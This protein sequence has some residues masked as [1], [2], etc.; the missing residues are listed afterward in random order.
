MFRIPRKLKK[1]IKKDYSVMS[2]QI[3]RRMALYKSS[4]ANYQKLLENVIDDIQ[5]VAYKF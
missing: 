4:G 1:K 5:D 2:Y 3:W